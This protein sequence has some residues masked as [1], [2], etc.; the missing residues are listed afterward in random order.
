MDNLIL[1]FIEYLIVE[2]GLS[3][4]TIKAYRRD[5]KNFI[6]YLKTQGIIDIN[7]TSRTII[8]S[9]LLFM[10]KD[11]KASSTISRASASI[12]SFYH[13]LFRERHIDEDPTINLDSPKIE[14]RLPRVLTIEEVDLLLNQPDIS[15]SLGYRDKTMLELLYATGMR[16]SELV[17]LEKSDV[18]LD[19]GYLRCF[20]K[21]SKERI[22]PIGSMALKYLKDYVKNVRIELLKDKNVDF[23]FLNH[24]GQGLSRQGFWKI[25]KKYAKKANLSKKITPHTLRHS[26]AT[27][28]LEN[29]ADLRAVQE[30]LGHT[31][32]ATTQIYTHITKNRLKEVYDKSHPRA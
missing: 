8:I 23:L 25:V 15:T 4:N 30:M 9:Y 18:N 26:F 3:D 19:L 31:D 13:F 12:K 6:T 21:G 14:H 17:S 7:Q 22:L 28:L 32:I 11:G 10:Q 29:G 20:G 24:H 1:E 2:R 5:L 16:V 27:H